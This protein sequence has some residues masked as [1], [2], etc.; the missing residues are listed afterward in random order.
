MII[1]IL[2]ILKIPCYSY[3]IMATAHLF[4][5]VFS[6]VTVGRHESSRIREEITK[7]KSGH[8]LLLYGYFLFD[9]RKNANN[10]IRLRRVTEL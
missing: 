5:T 8:N 10:G 9:L 1:S 3:Y 2:E 6:G 4:P 7:Y